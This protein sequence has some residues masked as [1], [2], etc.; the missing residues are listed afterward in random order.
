MFG[1][2]FAKGFQQNVRQPGFQ[3]DHQTQ[4]RKT[5][6]QKEDCFEVEFLHDERLPY[7]CAILASRQQHI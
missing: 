3:H 1:E 2:E 6:Y 4:Q 5:I 7:Q